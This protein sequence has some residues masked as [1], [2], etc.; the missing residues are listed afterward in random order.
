LSKDYQHISDEE[1]LSRFGSDGNNDWLGI[2]LERYTM[3]LFGV[4]M[5]YLKHEEQAKDAVQQV[6]LKALSEVPKYKIDNIGG[7][8]YQVARNLCLS[9]LRSKKEYSDEE[10][11][12][13][14]AQPEEVPLSLLIEKEKDI[15]RL[16]KELLNLKE[17]QRVCI[18]AFYLEKK[19]YQQIS[20][21]TGF[22][23]KQ[24]K[25]HI[26]NGKRN[27]KLKLESN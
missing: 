26:Q 8:L 6:F 19:S 2:L 17:E 4:C 7:W 10:S 12:Q 15:D 24:V 16:K 23:I 3:L 1:L 11:L 9:N 5:K 25:S 18:A 21:L 14:I 22:S 20:E 27:L 13:Y